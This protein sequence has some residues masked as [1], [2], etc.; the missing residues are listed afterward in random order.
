MNEAPLDHELQNFGRFF[1][2]IVKLNDDFTKNFGQLNH[3]KCVF[4]SLVI[5]WLGDGSE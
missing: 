3:T 1:H 5:S 4:A 2:G